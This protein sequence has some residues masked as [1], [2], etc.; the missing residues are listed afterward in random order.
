MLPTAE[1]TAPIVE[2]NKEAELALRPLS[3]VLSDTDLA[4]A[5]ARAEAGEYDRKFVFGRRHGHWVIN[6]ETWETNK[7]AAN[8]SWPAGLLCCIICFVI[9]GLHDACV[10]HRR[11][12]STDGCQLF[13]R[14]L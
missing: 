4:T 9:A 10:P 7:I 6:G 14:E 2:F 3:K 13:E 1:A 5:I 12:G 11:T 8:V